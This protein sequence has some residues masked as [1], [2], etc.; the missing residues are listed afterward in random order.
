VDQPT[1]QH[2][3]D[4]VELNT[5]SFVV[6]IW[7]EETAA[8]TKNPLWRGHI[9]HVPSGSRRYLSRLSGILSFV[10]PYLKDMGIRFNLRSYLRNQF[11][12]WMNTQSRKRLAN[13]KLHIE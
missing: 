4:L 8:E 12:R 11:K 9:T 3:M 7:I 6:K 1:E 5:H 10:K 2:D 13:Q